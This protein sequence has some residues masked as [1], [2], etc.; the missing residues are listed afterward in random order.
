MGLGV[1]SDHVASANDLADD[2]RVLPLPGVAI[3]KALARHE[4][5]RLD[6]EVV[7]HVQELRRRPAGRPV[8]E[9][10]EN[11]ATP[12]SAAN[13]QT[14]RKARAGHIQVGPHDAKH[15][16]SWFGMDR[17]DDTRW[18]CD[19]GPPARSPPTGL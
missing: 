17:L 7:E 15:L 14:A 11:S 19:A 1:V 4:E 16:G 13:R 8:V 6:A 12:R 2:F 10:E 3:A 9:R 5:E 18:V